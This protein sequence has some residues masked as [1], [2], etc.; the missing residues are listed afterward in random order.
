MTN[1]RDWLKTTL[2]LAA[3][4]PAGTV[5]AEKLMAAPA[6]ETEKKFFA[7]YKGTPVKIRLGSNENPYGPS[8]KARQAI[9]QMITE[10]NRYPFQAV[11]EFKEVLAAKEGVTPDYIA[12]GAGS[13]DLLAATGA[14]FGLTGGS[15]LSAFPT[16]PSLMTYAE[17]FNC[18]WD[19]VN[20]DDQLVCDYNA[21]ASAIKDDT[22]LVFV[23]NP[24]NP[25]GTVVDHAIVRAFCEEVSKKVPVFADEAYL[26]FLEPA[27]QISMVELVK[28]GANVI[29]SRTFSKIH[30][31]AGLRIGYIIAKPEL[32]KK[33]TRNQPGIS[34]NQIAIGAAKACLADSPTFMEMSRKKNAEARKHLTEYL[35]KKS[36]FYGKSQTN[37]VMW[38][39][40]A[41]A[42]QIL[43]KM[44]DRGIAI[45]VWD[46]KGMQWLR[47]SIGT[48]DEMKVFTKA[49]DEILS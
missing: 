49:Y 22:R 23:C 27:Q 28:K 30:G 47:V 32:I 9:T 36:L 2:T 11:T 31:I 29:V 39:P 46:Y 44:A 17:V 5:L 8:E 38:D 16:Y 21:M 14:S 3:G 10:A 25:T 13:S 45:R 6:S 19:K 48:L 34:N 4:L 26:E 7:S 43:A 15:I 12:V 33:I 40:K 24:N 1:R 41:D 35:N 18:R 37:F 42:A 20:V